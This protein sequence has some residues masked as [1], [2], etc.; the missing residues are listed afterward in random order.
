MDSNKVH[1]LTGWHVSRCQVW[2]LE[3][4]PTNDGPGTYCDEFPDI[5][6]LPPADDERN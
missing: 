3:V 5:P 2:R 1:S 4:S 6:W